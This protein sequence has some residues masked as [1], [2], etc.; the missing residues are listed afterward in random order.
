MKHIIRRLFY[1]G[2]FLKRGALFTA[3]L[4]AI[5]ALS[6]CNTI[7][8]DRIPAMPVNIDLSNP[9]LWNVYGVHGYGQC[10][11]FNRET[12]EPRDFAYLAKTY[13]GFGGVLLVSGVNPFTLEAGSPMAYDLACP[14]ECKPQIRV[15]IQS[16]GSIP[17]A[18]CPQCGSAYDIT[19]R[20]GAPK[21]GP[22][23]S[24]KVGLQ[25]YECHPTQYGGY[26]ILDR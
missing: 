15:R 6:G 9:A 18:V 26:M 8:D 25:R 1:V 10:R 20:G 23:L 13:T 21:S 24:E 7:D 22:A 19:E 12:G 2:A 16:D 3:V 17:T 14:V 11:I 4:F 5:F